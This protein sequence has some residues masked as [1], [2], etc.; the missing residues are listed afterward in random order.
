MAAQPVGD[1]RA[2]GEGGHKK[3]PERGAA[4][5]VAQQ[6]SAQDR[7]VTDRRR[8]RRGDRRR[9][10]SSS[11]S[12]G[13]RWSGIV[14]DGEVRDAGRARPRAQDVL[15]RGEAAQEGRP[16]RP[17]EQPHRCP[18][19][20]HRRHRRR[21]AVRQRR[22]LQGPRGPSR[23]RTRVAAR[24]PRPRRAAQRGRRADPS[25]AARR[26]ASR[27]GRAVS[28]G[29]R[30]AGLRLAGIDLEALGLLRA[31]VEP[32]PFAARTADDTATVVVAMGHESSTLLV[33][34]GGV[35]EF[36]RVFDWGGGD[37]AGRDRAGARGP[38]RRGGDDP[39]PSLT[40]GPGSPV[41]GLD[42][43]VARQGARRDP[44]PPDAVRARA[45]ELAPVLPDSARI[46]RHR[47]DRHHRWHLAARGSR[48]RAP[49]DDRR[50]RHASAIPLQRVVREPQGSTSRLEGRSVRWRFR[51]GSRSTTLR[52]RSV[53]LFQDASTETNKPGRG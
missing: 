37:A 27:S 34:G 45:R 15:R 3:R 7:R 9:A 29:R 42:D 40:V 12:H 17:R 51:S 44:A 26:R 18:H 33:A 28:G 19:A 48:R 39:P 53:N 22:S 20:R 16:D 1:C 25:R 52:I 38:S 5:P 46:A 2:R 35:C 24:L 6:S 10:R 47:R 14:V 21:G 41:R 13:G 32:R 30:R 8:G 49:P 43:D 31:F 11:S 50:L 23:C 36:T 4:E